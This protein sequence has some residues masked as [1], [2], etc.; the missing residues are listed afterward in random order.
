MAEETGVEWCDLTFN[1]WRGCKKK[2]A[3]CGNCYAARFA[4]FNPAV[5]GSWGPGRPRVHAVG[6]YV[7][8]VAR[9]NERAGAGLFRECSVCGRRGFY[10]RVERPFPGGL[11][12]CPNPDCVALPE[13]ES[14]VARPRVFSASMADWLDDD[15]AVPVGWLLELL[16]LVHGSPN[17]DW[18]LL[19][20]SPEVWEERLTLALGVDRI[21]TGEKGGAF[22][23]WLTDW[24]SG[25]ESPRNVWVGTSVE[26][27]EWA[28][29][30]IPALLRIPAAVRFLSVEPMLGPVNLEWALPW[31]PNIEAMRPTVLRDE[32]ERLAERD[33]EHTSLIHW[34]ICGGESGSRARVF[35]PCW[36]I[37]L[38]RQCERAG[39]PFFMKQM[40]ARAVA[41]FG[42]LRGTVVCPERRWPVGAEFVPSEHGKDLVKLH[43][44]KGGDPAEWPEIYRR[45]EFPMVGV[46]PR[47]TTV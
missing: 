43:H 21:E 34:V 12:G 22:R 42:G 25:E 37:D 41:D 9:W 4:Q 47:R 24:L 10:K 36:A 8:Q 32:L 19:T 15:E 13:Q 29:K 14:D 20:K 46:K 7:A 45:R 11:L 31:K 17:L 1:L 30:R 27:Q 2:S 40:G 33:R 28:D 35:D 18:L 16:R 38:M 6:S 39:V 5:L 23:R 44:K 26:N 3:G